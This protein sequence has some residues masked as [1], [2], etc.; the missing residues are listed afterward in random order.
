[1]P[2]EFDFTS[3]ELR[4]YDLVDTSSSIMM[5]VL[6]SI[7]TVRWNDAIGFTLPR[8]KITDTERSIVCYLDESAA[9]EVMLITDLSDFE[10]L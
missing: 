8:F 10:G 9:Y 6:G 2:W 7:I 3:F 4:H 1:M 5:V